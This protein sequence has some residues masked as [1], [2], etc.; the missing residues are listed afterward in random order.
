MHAA[1]KA[2]GGWWSKTARST[3]VETIPGHEVT[4]IVESTVRALTEIWS[5]DLLGSRRRA[6]LRP[7]N[8]VVYPLSLRFTS[9]QA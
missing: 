9:S 1:A 6:S 4:L 3:C 2:N 7:I 5:G 8:N